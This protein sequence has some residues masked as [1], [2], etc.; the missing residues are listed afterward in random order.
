MP[1]LKASVADTIVICSN[2]A[3][4]CR[5]LEHLDGL[6]SWMNIKPKKSPSLSAT[7]GKTDAATSFTMAKKQIPSVSEEPVKSLGRWYDS[8]RKDAKRGHETEE[9][10][11]ESLLA[12]NRCGLQCEFKVCCLQFTLI[13]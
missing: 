11:T 12:I 6:M 9:L 5:M 2:E 1:H 4:T 10:A 8:S 3:E 13:P 7:K